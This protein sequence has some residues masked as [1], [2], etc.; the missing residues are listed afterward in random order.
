M[1]RVVITI[2]VTL[3]KRNR[4]ESPAAHG[5]QCTKNG[6]ITN[7]HDRFVS[8]LCHRIDFVC[9]LTGVVL[10]QVLLEQSNKMEKL[11]TTVSNNYGT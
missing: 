2:F 7:L 10:R 6:H 8:H 11:V 3:W 5:V 9:A 1:S 4:N